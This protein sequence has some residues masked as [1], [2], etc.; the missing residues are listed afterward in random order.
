VAPVELQITTSLDLLFWKYC[1]CKI[2][3]FFLKIAYSGLFL[4]VLG[5]FD[6]LKL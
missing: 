3:A 4:A 6:Q 2:L 1:R 5:N